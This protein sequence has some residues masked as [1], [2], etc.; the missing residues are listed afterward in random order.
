MKRLGGRVV[1]GSGAGWA[2]K[3]DG[4]TAHELVEYKTVLKGNTQITLK[5]AD[6][7]KITTEALVEGRNA[8]LGFAVGGR[9]YVVQTEDQYEE[10][11]WL[12][13][14]E[15]DKAPDTPA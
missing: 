6:L 13:Y 9:N 4:R 12:A 1:P 3:G 2:R 14:G 5:A 8:L 10:M 11:R 7:K 15:P